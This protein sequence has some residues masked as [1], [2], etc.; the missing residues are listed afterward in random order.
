MTRL[1]LRE[2]VSAGLVLWLLWQGCQTVCL[3]P[4]ALGREGR[5]GEEHERERSQAGSQTDR[6]M[7]RTGLIILK[8]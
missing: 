4:S 5:R 1:L 6:E 2:D 7:L 3:Q 8:T